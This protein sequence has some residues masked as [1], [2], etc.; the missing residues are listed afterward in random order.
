M[1]PDPNKTPSLKNIVGLRFLNFGRY[2]N[3]S[4]YPSPYPHK[5]SVYVEV[6]KEPKFTYHLTE[7]YLVAYDEET[8]FMNSFE[9]K[10]GTRD[11][12]GGHK[13][14]LPVHGQGVVFKNKGITRMTFEGCLWDSE[15]AKQTCYSFF[16]LRGL[17]VAYQK[18]GKDLGISAEIREDIFYSA[19]LMTGMLKGRK[20]A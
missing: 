14:V 19:L 3:S 18:R 2:E 1:R 9:I 16:G 4:V 7:N 13:F 10:K 20:A 17:S 11:G 12:F 8:G 6:M 15:A 5:C